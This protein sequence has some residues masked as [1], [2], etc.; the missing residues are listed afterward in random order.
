MNRPYAPC[1][2]W[3]AYRAHLPTGAALQR[4]STLLD[5]LFRA[6]LEELMTGRVSVTRKT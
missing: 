2:T 1:D 4:E 6:L 5:E 3:A